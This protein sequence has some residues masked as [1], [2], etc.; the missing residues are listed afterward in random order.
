MSTDKKIRA[1]RRKMAQGDVDAAY[2]LGAL[3]CKIGKI[4]IWTLLEDD[5]YGQAVTVFANEQDAHD[6][7]M[8]YMENH[9]DRAIGD[10]VA[11]PA[12]FVDA[13]TL[14]S[15]ET[16]GYHITVDEHEIQV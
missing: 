15:E 7:A 5:R 12:D 16:E 9:W 11:M 1:L 13:Y 10:H 14:F 8:N 6:A 3:E 2:A 4:K